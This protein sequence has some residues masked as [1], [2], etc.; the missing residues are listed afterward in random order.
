MVV[1]L[2]SFVNFQLVLANDGGGCGCKVGNC[3]FFESYVGR[4][5]LEED[6][7]YLF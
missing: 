6:K 2:V 1:V 3:L 4:G 5:G 7:M